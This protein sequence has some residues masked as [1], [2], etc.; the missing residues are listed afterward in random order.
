MSNKDCAINNQS[1]AH[2]I[3]RRQ[4]KQPLN[5]MTNPVFLAEFNILY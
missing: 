5:L 1:S 2:M 4:I 3:R